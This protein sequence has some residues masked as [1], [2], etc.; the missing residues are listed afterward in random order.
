VPGTVIA[1]DDDG[2]VVM[3]G[4]DALAILRAQLPGR[5]VVSAA[6]LA[7]ARPLVGKVLGS[8]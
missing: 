2:I 4:H 8:H 6:E 7:N 5:R 3:A 1:A